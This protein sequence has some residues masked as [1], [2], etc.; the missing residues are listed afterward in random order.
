MKQ[1]IICAILLL[2]FGI[3]HSQQ[4]DLGSPSIKNN[5]LEK[6]KRQQKTAL[7]LLCSGTALEIAGAITYKYGSESIFLLGTGLLSQI[8]SLP[9]LFSSIINKK[10]AKKTSLSI[11]IERTP[12]F[13]S[14]S[15]NVHSNPVIGLNINF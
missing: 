10:K 5:Y 14:I 13:T 12:C 2:L 3:S 15:E 1:I 6:S 4:A 11:K 9:F 8:A 7:I